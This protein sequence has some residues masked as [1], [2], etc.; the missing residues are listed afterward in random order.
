MT[1]YYE[2]VRNLPVA[3][4]FYK[5]T[6]THPIRRTVL[7]IESNARFI[8]GYEL[9]EGTEVRELK[10]APIKSY[11]RQKIARDRQVSHRRKEGYDTSTLRRFGLL[12]ALK[13]V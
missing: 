3:K 4:F 10:D 1:T 11:S 2:P 7:V 5:G 12:E 9:R 6:H 13:N 8:R